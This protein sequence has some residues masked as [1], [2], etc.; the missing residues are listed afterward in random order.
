MEF[1]ASH[2]T[3]SRLSLG[4]RLAAL[5]AVALLAVPALATAQSGP[6]NDQYGDIPLCSEV[7]GGSGGDPSEPCVLTS[8][9][10]TGSADPGASGLGGNVGPLPFTGFDVIAMV[11]V[12]LAVAGVGLALQRA[13]ARQSQ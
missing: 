11:A 8:S 6:T 10:S 1:T 7:S 12:A 2:T 9:G 3:G 13:V 5:L 4:V